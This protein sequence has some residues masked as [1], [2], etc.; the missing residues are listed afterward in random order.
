MAILFRAP[1]KGG[2]FTT[3][4]RAACKGNDAFSQARKELANGV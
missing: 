3:E 4:E 2:M 1:T